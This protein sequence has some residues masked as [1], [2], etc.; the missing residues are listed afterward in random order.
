MHVTLMFFPKASV[1]LKDRLSGL[2]EEVEWAP[3]EASVSELTVHRR[4]SIVAALQVSPDQLEPLHDRLGRAS[5]SYDPNDAEAVARAERNWTGPL[6]L[7]NR[8]QDQ[9]ELVHMRRRDRYSRP[10]SLH[11]TLARISKHWDVETPL[12]AMPKVNF[13]LD[14]VA[15]FESTLS[16][17]GASHTQISAPAED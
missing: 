14:R 13:V 17:D 8:E 5:M 16:A 15:L 6:A 4:S 3:I 1:E 2:M 11:V 9:P 7:M 10:L 12:P